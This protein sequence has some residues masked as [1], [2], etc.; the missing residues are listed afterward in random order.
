[1]N[2]KRRKI[3]L[4]K[5]FLS[6][7]R[8]MCWRALSK[9]VFPA[10]EH[11]SMLYS[12]DVDGI[13]D[14]G[15][16][17][18][19]FSLACRLSLPKLS[20]VAFE[21]VPQEAAIFRYVH[22]HDRNVFLIESALGN[23]NGE[24]DLYLSKSADNSSLLP[25]GELQKRLSPDSQEVSVIKVPV[26]RLDDFRIHWIN[27]SKLLLK[28]DVQGF[29]LQVL[30]GSVKTLQHCSYVY[31]ECSEVE[32]YKGQS[33]RADVSEF[34]LRHGF[35]QSKSI[36]PTYVGKKLVQSNYLFVR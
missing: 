36:D 9:R 13:I 4:K 24:S 26:A 8:P 14:I 6:L 15:A 28:I 22:G 20:L 27:C 16:N 33:L 19:Q 17:R 21:P 1:M 30:Y 34:L 35:H 11:I 23:T 5:L 3:Q 32:L 29:E 12:L 18:G 10:L 2:I 7:S 25:I 31:V